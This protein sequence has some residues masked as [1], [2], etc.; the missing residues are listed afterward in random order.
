MIPKALRGKF[1]LAIR[2]TAVSLFGQAST[3]SLPCKA[4]WMRARLAS[5]R[6][7]MN[8][9]GKKYKQHLRKQP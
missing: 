5:A 9:F 6:T 3:A 7:A 8:M 2:M 4:F 1:E